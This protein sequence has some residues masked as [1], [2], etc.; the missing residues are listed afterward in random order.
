MHNADPEEQGL[1]LA[2]EHVLCY[3]MQTLTRKGKAT[4]SS[5][6]LKQA[7]ARDSN[8]PINPYTCLPDMCLPLFKIYMPSF[9]QVQA[10]IEVPADYF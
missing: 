5:Q 7:Q 8:C 10:K 9:P 6:Q 4:Y 2:P 3:Q 1:T